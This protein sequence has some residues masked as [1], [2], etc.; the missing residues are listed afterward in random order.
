MGGVEF[1][2]YTKQLSQFEET[3][4]KEV[5]PAAKKK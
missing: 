5:V 1:L 2:P 4:T 3:A